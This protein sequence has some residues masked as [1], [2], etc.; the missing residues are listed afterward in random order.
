MV[1]FTEIRYDDRF[2]WAKAYH[3]KTER[4]FDVKVFRQEWRCEISPD[5]YDSEVFKAAG[6]LLVALNR[7]GF[8]PKEYLVMWG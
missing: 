8:L 1:N 2:I 7:E 5:D 4:C 3:P 6:N